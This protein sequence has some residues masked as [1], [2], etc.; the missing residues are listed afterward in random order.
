ML[1]KAPVALALLGFGLGALL[2]NAVARSSPRPSTT[3]LADL[4]TRAIEAQRISAIA[5]QRARD[6]AARWSAEY[7][8]R[9][10]ASA[11]DTATDRERASHDA[12]ERS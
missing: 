12:L 1:R 7:D 8:R 6:L 3:T 10:A 9:A 5:S 2:V 11:H 4:R